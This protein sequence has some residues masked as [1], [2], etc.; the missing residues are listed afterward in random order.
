MAVLVVII[1]CFRNP[2]LGQE[3]AFNTYG[4][5]EGLP[6]TTV[7]DIIQDKKGYLWIATHGGA[8]RFDG[9]NFEE[10]TTSQ[11]LET[12]NVYAV[13]EDHFGNIWIGTSAGISVYSESEIE[14]RFTHFN[15]KN[16]FNSK[17][18]YVFLE[19]DGKMLI[20]SDKGVYAFSY[21]S[22]HENPFG[23]DSLELSVSAS[24]QTVEGR[25][26]VCMFDDSRGQLW[27]G[28]DSGLVVMRNGAKYYTKD[29]GMPNNEILC[30][31]EDPSH[32]LWVGTGNGAAKFVYSDRGDLISLDAKK[33][34][35]VDN[36]AARI[37]D[38]VFL[39]DGTMYLANPIVGVY[40]PSK[41]EEL[42]YR[43][44][45]NLSTANG[46]H[47]SGILDIFR[48]REGNFWFG[49]ASSGLAMLIGR[50]FETYTTNFGMSTNSVRAITK[51]Q[52]NN[53][54]LGTAAFPDVFK[55]P[56]DQKHKD[57]FDYQFIESINTEKGM[58]TSSIWSL[59]A[60]DNRVWVGGSRG[61]CLYE[62]G[63]IEQFSSREGFLGK[64]VMRQ[65]KDRSGIMWF[66]S[67]QGVTCYDVAKDSLY[68][69][70][71]KN[72]P[73][74]GKR[75][76]Y[77]YQD[78]H[79]EFWFASGSGLVHR[80]IGYSK[81]FTMEDGLPSNYVSSIIPD[82]NG[83][84]WLATGKGISF[85]DGES[86]TNYSTQDGLS[87]D[88]PY[89]MIFDDDQQL[90]VG[91]NKGLDR[92]TID[93]KTNS[94]TDIE[95]YGRE[96]GFVG[97][98]TNA[99]AVFKDDNGDLWFG[100]VG[101]ATRY[102][103]KFDRENKEEPITLITRMRVQFEDQPLVDDLILPYNK[104][105]IMFDFTGISLQAPKKVRYKFRLKGL[106]NEWSPELQ[107]TYTTYSNLASGAYTFQ[108]LS[109]NGHGRWNKE[110]TEYH[111][112]ITPPFWKT[113]WFILL[114]IGVVGISIFSY[115]QWRTIRFKRE[116]ER[117]EIKVRERTRALNEQN[118][119][120]EQAKIEIERSH[121][122]LASKNRDIT[123]SI[124]YAQRIQQGMLPA[125]DVIK[126][127]FTDCFVLYRP[128]DIVSGDFYWMQQ[129]EDK[130]FFAAVDCTG[131]GVPGAMV[132]VLGYN[133]LNRTIREFGKRTPASI[134]DKL[135]EIVE[136]A[137]SQSDKDV[138]DGMDIAL[139]SIYQ[140]GEQW[141]LE[142]AG[143][144]NPLWL[145]K[146]ATKSIE[147]VKANKQPIGVYDDRVP[148]A[149]NVMDVEKGDVIYLFSDGFAD[150]FGGEKGKK[151]KGRKFR[152]LLQEMGEESMEIQHQQMNREFDIWKANY[153]Q[154]DD[155]CII[156]I[157]I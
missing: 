48:D 76:T 53:L 34:V 100:T 69:A 88:T 86:F 67:F 47:S 8:A 57:P 157:R 148:F 126:A 140:E 122:Q 17:R 125:E 18:A 101:G 137:F 29:N 136:D 145:Y 10:F 78:Q 27:M 85:F 134:L 119:K 81:Q 109:C 30:I 130:T 24:Y 154:V 79:D 113:W 71:S 155:V 42:G 51:D 33:E 37:T 15:D 123:D 50:H 7:E 32:N 146:R 106:E 65:F 121:S 43:L 5:D 141:K 45:E 151:L 139:C 128:K 143:A 83:N 4:L 98:E 56:S 60:E 108:V 20:G 149:N 80:G 25:S 35:G 91:T 93:Y 13:Y 111:F 110:P 144:N 77:V 72:D 96:E 127:A 70:F 105:H 22:F 12:N 114:F 16:G 68:S 44:R 131:H 153:P 133:A 129:A 115:V 66:C 82:K 135:N 14:P 138:R 74:Y 75:L 152:E 41:E 63:Q 124:L 19:R 9:H 38:I 118:D 3:Y 90:W 46:M 132:S 36:R 89:L 156:G 31:A 49:G 52:D 2:A 55:N 147:E 11:G 58:K 61:L 103:K 64:A 26:I 120:L 73:L 117:L 54:W 62:D 102:Q 95:F 39:E 84:F 116:K 104:N 87:S 99:N 142:Y 150:Q 107:E 23:N 59:Y 92:L 21:R 6:Q 97:V 1:F 94:I 40:E 28:T 112:V